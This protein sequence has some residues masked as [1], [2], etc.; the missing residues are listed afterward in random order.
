MEETKKSARNK[1]SPLADFSSRHCGLSESDTKIMLKQ[2]DVASL[3]K[4]GEKILPDNIHSSTAPDLGE[5]LN[6]HEALR[7]RNI[8]T[9]SLDI[10]KS[11]TTPPASLVIIVYLEQPLAKVVISAGII[12]DRA[13][14][15]PRLEKILVPYGKHQKGKQIF[16]CVNALQEDLHQHTGEAVSNWKKKPSCPQVFRAKKKEESLKTSY[17]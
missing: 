15:H 16:W 8:S 12:A 7:T 14:R 2:L 3:E 4:L 17:F 1:F 9:P 6:E 5:A 10:I 11:S 13:Q